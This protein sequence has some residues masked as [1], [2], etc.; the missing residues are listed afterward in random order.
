MTA[1][2][3]PVHTAEQRRALRPVT[4]VYGEHARILLDA[5]R[6]HAQAEAPG[7]PPPGPAAGHGAWHR[8]RYVFLRARCYEHGDAATIALLGGLMK[9]AAGRLLLLEPPVPLHD[10]GSGPRSRELRMLGNP[11]TPPA[12]LV[13]H[14]CG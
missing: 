8:R 12:L 9:R 7:E 6:I 14:L 2:S 13:T 5:N 1:D 3:A 11:E 10:F 4:S